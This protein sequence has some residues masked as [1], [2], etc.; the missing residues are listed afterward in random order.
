MEHM[1]L[2]GLNVLNLS[3]H[4]PH[5]KMAWQ[6]LG[7]FFQMPYLVHMLGLVNI[8]CGAVVLGALLPKRVVL[9]LALVVLGKWFCFVFGC[10]LRGLCCMKGWWCWMLVF[11]TCIE[12][13]LLWPCCAQ[14]TAAGLVRSWSVLA[15]DSFGF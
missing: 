7:Y 3:Q 9:G 4:K 11:I 10:W 5:T 12:H 13:Q 8:L 15:F 2:K 1:A 14:S 6:S